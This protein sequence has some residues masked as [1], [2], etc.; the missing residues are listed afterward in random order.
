MEVCNVCAAVLLTCNVC[1]FVCLQVFATAGWAVTVMVFIHYVFTFATRKN[2]IPWRFFKFHRLARKLSM[3]AI[4]VLFFVVLLL[5]IA[6]AVEPKCAVGNDS[7][8]F[9]YEDA[10]QFPWLVTIPVVAIFAGIASHHKAE[11][12]QDATIS[13]ES[14]AALL[15]EM[16]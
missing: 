12:R 2:E 15:G 3:V 11:D 13:C 5:V 6:I 9:W 7:G 10:N 14:Y 16:Y 8:S 4:G 1:F